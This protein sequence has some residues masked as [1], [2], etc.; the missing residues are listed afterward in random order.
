[1]KATNIKAAIVKT[2]LGI[3]AMG[4]LLFAGTSKADAQVFVGLGFGHPVRP[5][6]VP[7]YPRPGF[8]P[9]Y[10][11]HRFYGYDRRAYD[12]DRFRHE[13]FRRDDRRFDHDHDGWRR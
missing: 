12:Y 2:T 9:G 11:D 1:M 7:A 6:V 8:Y 4:A 10:Y 5:I 13:D 3:A